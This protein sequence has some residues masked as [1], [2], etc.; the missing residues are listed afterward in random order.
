MDRIKKMRERKGKK[1]IE[2]NVSNKIKDLAKKL[3]NNI[4]NT[5]IL[6]DEDKK[7]IKFNEGLFDEVLFK[8]LDNQKLS[9]FNKKKPKKIQ[10]IDN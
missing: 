9:K 5:K 2:L 1:T 6:K 10:F 7:N 4:E 3:E 8:I